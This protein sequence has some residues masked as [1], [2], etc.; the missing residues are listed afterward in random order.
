AQNRAHR[1]GAVSSAKQPPARMA[2]DRLPGSVSKARA[3]Q[4][5]TGATGRSPGR[6][7]ALCCLNRRKKNLY[8]I[9]KYNKN[10]K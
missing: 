7:H 2:A 9:K 5:L 8:A 6:W 3:Q 10:Q 4:R 1:P